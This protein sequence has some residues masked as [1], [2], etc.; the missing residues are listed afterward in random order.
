MNDVNEATQTLKLQTGVRRHVAHFLLQNLKA[1]P[2]KLPH[3]SERSLNSFIS[4]NPP[5]AG[6]RLQQQIC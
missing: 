4:V 5:T 2:S 6:E 1:Y 3:E